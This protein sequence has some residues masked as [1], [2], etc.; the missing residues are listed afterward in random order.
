MPPTKEDEALAAA[1]AKAAAAQKEL[2]AAQKAKQ[3]ADKRK[4]EAAKSNKPDISGGD[5]GGYSD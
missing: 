4:V 5:D 3:E 1:K 2:E